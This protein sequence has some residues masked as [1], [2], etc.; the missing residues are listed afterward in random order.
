[1]FKSECYTFS[2]SKKNGAINKNKGN[3]EFTV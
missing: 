3:N 1:M 2:A